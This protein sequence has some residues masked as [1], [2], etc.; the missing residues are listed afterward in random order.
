M[1][2]IQSIIKIK[3][4]TPSVSPIS[5]KPILKILERMESQREADDQTQLKI[6]PT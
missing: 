5:I 2:K 1:V 6:T 3:T 4:V